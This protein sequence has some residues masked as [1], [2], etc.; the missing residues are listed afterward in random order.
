MSLAGSMPTIK[1]KA[2]E[3]RR[4]ISEQIKS[5]TR[6]SKQKLSKVD[7]SSSEREVLQEHH[8]VLK[9]QASGVDC[10]CD[11]VASIHALNMAL[12]EKDLQQRKS[13]EGVMEMFITR[14]LGT[15]C[16]WLTQSLVKELIDVILTAVGASGIMSTVV[17]QFALTLIY[18]VVLAIFAPPMQFFL[19]KCSYGK[20]TRWS[21]MVSLQKKALPLAIAWAFKDVVATL[22]NVTDLVFSDE[23]LATL[24]LILLVTLLQNA[25]PVIEARREIKQGNDSV[26]ARYFALPM[27]LNLSVGYAFSQCATCLVTLLSSHDRDLP[28][29]AQNSI[30]L[31]LQ[32]IYFQMMSAAVI[33][34]S[35]RWSLK[36]TTVA[37][38]HFDWQQ[39][40]VMIEDL[41]REIEADIGDT[42]THALGFVYGWG[43]S[44]TLRMMYYPFFMESPSYKQSKLQHV[45]YFAFLVSLVLGL[46]VSRLST[47]EYRSAASKSYRELM[48]NGMSLTVG[49]AWMNVF[50]MTTNAFVDAWKEVYDTMW[51]A[52]VFNFILYIFTWVVMAQVYYVIMDELRVVKRSRDEF[53][54]AYPI[55]G[56][57]EEGV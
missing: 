53:H 11:N 45:W 14:S 41:L 13:Q 7:V 27:G 47:S 6:D 32:L 44:D 31:L 28:F 2:V 10:V 46:F 55:C 56:R 3:F 22:L 57:D 4:T 19:R 50:E 37:S 25:R 48:I 18:A 24:A 36:K 8:E 16:A 1:Q 20:T 43:L 35:S 9:S 26:V 52:L 42:V 34:I 15:G 21:S 17:Y 54:E 30:L 5:E 51:T 12:R 49:W 23:L 38:E 40:S 33:Q 29:A 39:H